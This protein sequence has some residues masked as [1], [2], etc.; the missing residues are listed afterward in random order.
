MAAMDRRPHAVSD[1]RCWASL[2][3]LLSGIPLAGTGT[4][5]WTAAAIEPVQGVVEM[6]WELPDGLG[7]G[8]TCTT[9]LL[10][11]RT[12]QGVSANL[13]AAG[14]CA[15]PV[16]RVVAL[17]MPR[18]RPERAADKCEMSRT[19]AL[20]VMAAGWAVVGAAAAT[21][22]ATCVPCRRGEGA[23]A[24]AAR[25]P[26]PPRPGG[27][28]GTGGPFA[29]GDRDGAREMRREDSES[30]LSVEIGVLLTPAAP[31]KT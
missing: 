15:I 21:L 23:Q 26:G 3:L 28:G 13:S 5:A 4:W 1:I 27:G 16:G 9:Q 25:L 8:V 14:P 6:R 7:L 18:G 2:L 17:C 12:E 20:S 24:P 22:A 11:L 30:L 29:C 31:G 10:L 19:A